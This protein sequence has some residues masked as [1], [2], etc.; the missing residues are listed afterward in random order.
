MKLYDIEI[1]VVSNE[2]YSPVL[3]KFL[4]TLSGDD[5]FDDEGEWRAPHWAAAYLTKDNGYWV[6]QAS[7]NEGM[8]TIWL[9]EDEDPNMISWLWRDM[10]QSLASIDDLFKLPLFLG[11][12]GYGNIM[13]PRKTS[14]S[15]RWKVLARSF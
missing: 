12:T 8:K 1:T 13:P 10:P 9:M 6:T 5:A 15:T 11:E 14:Y 4:L 7:R 2:L 3:T